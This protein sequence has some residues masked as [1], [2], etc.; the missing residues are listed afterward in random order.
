M[1]ALHKFD[2]ELKKVND[3]DFLMLK[4]VKGT[5]IRFGCM[6]IFVAADN[7]KLS[8]LSIQMFAF[9]LILHWKA[10]NYVAINGKQVAIYQVL[11]HTPLTKEVFLKD[12][13]QKLKNFL[14]KLGIA[15]GIL[16]LLGLLLAKNFALKAIA[17]H[18][19]WLAL[20]FILM[21]LISIWEIKRSTR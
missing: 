6:I 15:C 13:Y 4:I 17:I 19:G 21:A 2:E 16:K 8:L 12:R 14:F 3:Y 9:A 10:Y 18:F 7:L 11:R 5:L 1:E 20:I